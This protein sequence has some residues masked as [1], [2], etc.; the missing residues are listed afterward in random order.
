[1]HKNKSYKQNKFL[2]KLYYSNIM[3]ILWKLQLFWFIHANLISVLII[4][5]K[6]ILKIF[7]HTFF[8]KEFIKKLA[9]DFHT[10]RYH[11]GGWSEEVNSC[12]LFL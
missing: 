3:M 4:K 1:M 6:K 10:V 2:L 11:C 9:K 5:I 12:I 8:L 7:I